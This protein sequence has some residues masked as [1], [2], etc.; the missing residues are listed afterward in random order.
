MTTTPIGPP[1]PAIDQGAPGSS[2]S[3]GCGDVFLA[4]V[5]SIL[6]AEP[7][8][9]QPVAPQAADPTPGEAV[10]AQAEDPQTD[11]TDPTLTVVTPPSVLAALAAGLPTLVAPAPVASAEAGAAAPS[12][13]T[14]VSGVTTGSIPSEATTTPAAPVVDARALS[15]PE[16]RAP[17]TPAAMP[18]TATEDEP[19]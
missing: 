6:D 14:A 8:L 16:D 5:Q 10:P 3:T 19:A 11:A 18:A 4:L 13:T 9:T 15:A 1:A 2:S 7:S 12:E 17:A